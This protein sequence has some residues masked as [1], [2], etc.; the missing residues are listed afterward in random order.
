MAT[1]NQLVSEI[2]NALKQPDSVPLR[3][4]IKLSIIHARN[5]IIR[6]SFEH[7]NYID[8]VLQQRY[9]IELIN[10]PDGDIKDS[11][12]L[13][14]T[15]IKRS[16]NKVPKPVRLTN[17]LPFH[18]IR[19]F[20]VENPLEIAFAKEAVSKFYAAL[21]GF[22]NKIT[23]DYINGYLYI[24][25]FDDPDYSLINSIIVE[26]VFEYPTEIPIET[27]D[28]IAN[29]ID[30]D[31]EFLISEDMVD[32]IKKLVLEEI[33]AETVKDTNEPNAINIIQ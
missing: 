30:D 9:K 1:I 23:Y 24:N 33:L 8:K 32:S 13:I 20:G 25:F 28:G 2:A 26:S 27:N 16:K 15:K 11:M 5:T 19:T 12:G 3:A 29:Y 4:A 31:N 22:A 21:P 10:V 7:H 14:D 17:N 18:S 6:Q